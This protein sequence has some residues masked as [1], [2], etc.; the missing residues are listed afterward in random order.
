M[1]SLFLILCF[2]AF[3]D[4]SNPPPLPDTE[5]D[6]EEVEEE[7]RMNEGDKQTEESSPDT[8]S[9]TEQACSVVEEMSLTELE[10]DTVGNSQ[11]PEEVEEAEQ[12]SPKITQGF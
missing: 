8:E 3:G 9:L 6:E 5:G 7:E 12:E 2:R 11:Y 4:K 1:L 10:E